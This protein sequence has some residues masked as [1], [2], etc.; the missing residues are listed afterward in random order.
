[1]SG[2]CSSICSRRSRWC[3]KWSRWHSAPWGNH[4]PA[5]KERE[6]ERER[7]KRFL[8][9]A[10]VKLN[11]AITN[12]VLPCIACFPV[13]NRHGRGRTGPRGRGR[14]LPQG[15]RMPDSPRRHYL[16]RRTQRETGSW[17]YLQQINLSLVCWKV[18]LQ[19]SV[20]INFL[21]T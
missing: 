21:C 11:H 14:R 16:D 19:T 18:P 20:G 8:S 6:R 15:R 1:M 12:A 5:Q 4:W 3:W 7:V 10:G 13:P 2:R 9:G 17:M